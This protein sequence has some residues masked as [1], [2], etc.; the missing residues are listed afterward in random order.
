MQWQK[1]SLTLRDELNVSPMFQPWTQRASFKG[2]GLNKTLRV[3]DLLDITASTVLVTKDLPQAKMETAMSNMIIDVSQSHNRKCYTQG[4]IHKC[5]TRSSVLYAF[6]QDRQVLPIETLWFQGYPRTTQ[7]PATINSG[8][9]K[10]FVGEAMS[11]P[12]VACVIYALVACVP[13]GECSPPAA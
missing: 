3:L 6:G 10:E 11:L 8:D 9:I 1:E 7:F 13:L 12:C 5:L 4:D 2:H